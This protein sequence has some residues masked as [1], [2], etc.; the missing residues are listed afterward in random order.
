VRLTD[1]QKV[2]LRELDATLKDDKHSP[3]SKS[4]KDKVKEFFQ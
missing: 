2:L 1:K 3:Q 4:W